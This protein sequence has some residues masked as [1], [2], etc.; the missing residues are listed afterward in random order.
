VLDLI[1]PDSGNVITQSMLGFVKRKVELYDTLPHIDLVIFTSR[2]SEF[3]SSGLETRFLDE[4]Q[5]RQNLLQ[6]AADASVAIGKSEKESVAIVGGD[7]DAST[8]GVLA[9]AKWRL[10]TDQ[11]RL[12]MRDLAEGR[13]PLGGGIAHHLIKTGEHGLAVRIQRICCAACSSCPLAWFSDPRLLPLYSRSWLGTWP[14][15]DAC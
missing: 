12:N 13:L 9:T 7:I 2:S 1:R 6:A 5:R 3:F 8:F 14:S 11:T 15:A 4:R 10:G